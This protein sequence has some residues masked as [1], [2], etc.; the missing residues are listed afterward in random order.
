[1]N[2]QLSILFAL[3]FVGLLLSMAI[4]PLRAPRFWEHR[5]PWIVAFWALAF[6]LPFAFQ[7]G[8]AEAVQ[9]HLETLL[10]DYIPF[11]ILVGA[12]YVAAG[13]L[14]LTGGQAGNPL[15]NALLLGMGAVLA[16]LVGTTGASMV[17][18]RPLLRSISHR[19][20]QAHTVVFFIFLVS[21]IGG[22]L[23]PI[24][25]PPLFLGFLHGVD[26]FWTLSHCS[27]PMVFSCVVLLAVYFAIDSRYWRMEKRQ[28]A[29]ELQRL[30]LDLRG[31]GNIA[32]LLGIVATVVGSGLLSKVWGAGFS[33]RVPG[34]PP[35]EIGW[36]D[37]LRDALLLGWAAVSL[38]TTPPG[39]RE[40]N[41]FTWG[42]VREVALLFAGI[43]ATLIPLVQ[44]LHQG[45]AGSLGWLV[46]AVHSPVRYFWAAGALSSFLDNAPTYLLFFNVAGGDA[47]RL[48]SE[49]TMLAAISCGAV[50]MGAN[51]YIGN[52]PNLLVKAVAEEN[53]VEM[54]SFVGYMGWS[55]SILLPLFAVVGAIFF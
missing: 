54:P 16:S 6:A 19:R 38:K 27:G 36:T 15:G 21:N 26:F 22:S 8:A 17:L 18:I 12:L 7:H 33:I 23:T 5:Q 2:T 32:V 20:H 25:D 31:A 4:L 49:G 50:F 3:P 43:F 30:P 14:F 29:V 48:M 37:V 9:L 11:L 44:I 46:D 13:G 42:P 40:A 45:S 41:G 52:A 51:S 39:V 47:A 53:G 55:A 24:G 10:H 34:A 35:I 1:M 28:G